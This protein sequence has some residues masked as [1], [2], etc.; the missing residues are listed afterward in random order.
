MITTGNTVYSYYKPKTVVHALTHF[1]SGVVSV[2]FS[3][4]PKPTK[5]YVT[6]ATVKTQNAGLLRTVTNIYYNPANGYVS[7]TGTFQSTDIA[8]I[9]G[10][11]YVE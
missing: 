7:L 6:S 11:K 1:E 9:V 10:I 5:H 4:D 8:E 3:N 2:L